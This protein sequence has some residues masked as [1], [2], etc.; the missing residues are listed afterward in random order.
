MNRICR[1]CSLEKNILDFRH[2]TRGDKIDISCVCK[3]CN[4]KN[5]KERHQKF[6]AE[7]RNDLRKRN[8][9]YYVKNKE[10]IKERQ[11]DKRSEWNKTYYKKNKKKVQK[12]Q[13]RRTKERYQTDPSFRIRKVVS[14]SIYRALT[15]LGSSKSGQSCLKF[16]E[17]SMRDLRK[18][19]E[20][21]F[22]AWMTWDNYGK[23]D[24]KK[25]NNNDPATWT[26]NIDHIIPQSDLPYVSME[27]ENFRKCWEL[28][29]LRPLNAK[30]NWFDGVRRNRHQKKAA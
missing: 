26:W 7:H 9:E 30:Q 11:K 24:A 12:I 27:D 25:W 1:Q 4:Y 13:Q 28:S 14:K 2:Q 3:K 22:E 16:L 19:I 21:Q 29:N 5:G 18:H 8:K 17:Y 23:Y 6:R 10:E 15:I 20:K